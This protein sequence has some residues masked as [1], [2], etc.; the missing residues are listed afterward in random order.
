MCDLC[1]SRITETLHLGGLCSVS[2]VKRARIDAVLA[3][4]GLFPSRSAAAGAVRAGEVRIG[5]DGPVALR[6]SQLVEADAGPAVMRTASRPVSKILR[7]PSVCPRYPIGAV[8]H[9]EHRSREVPVAAHAL[10]AR[11]AIA[12]RGRSAGCRR[13][14]RQLR[15]RRSNVRT[16]TCPP[17]PASGSSSRRRRSVSLGGRRLR[18]FIFLRTSSQ[19]PHR[20]SSRARVLDS[21]LGRW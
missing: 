7:I 15:P 11:L 5:R 18:T 8:S 9:A 2:A 13:R 1:V 21:K 19:G 17:P 10:A 4:R 14:T 20:C 6:P 3:D 12:P 16:P